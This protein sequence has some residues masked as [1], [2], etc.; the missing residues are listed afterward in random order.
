MATDLDVRDRFL[1][2]GKF[3]RDPETGKLGGCVYKLKRARLDFL[4]NNGE[5]EI[6]A[7]LRR[8][9]GLEGANRRV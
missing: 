7:A 2:D 9:G 3:S 1:V 4:R 5:V 6:P 8:E